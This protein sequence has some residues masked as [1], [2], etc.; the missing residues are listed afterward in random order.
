MPPFELNAGS[1]IYGSQGPTN[2]LLSL[3]SIREMFPSYLTEH[4][5]L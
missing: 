1:T 5:Q 3:G 2:E 4:P